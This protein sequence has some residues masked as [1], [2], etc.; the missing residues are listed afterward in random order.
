MANMTGNEIKD[1]WD[2]IITAYKETER[3]D[4]CIQRV[5]EEMNLEEALETFAAIAQIKSH[6]GRIYGKNRDEMEKIS[7]D[8]SCLK[9]E[10][11]NPLVYKGLDEIHPTHINQLITELLKERDAREMDD[12]E[13][14]L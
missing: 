8:E 14:E 1:C 13:P 6:D 12:I 11:G 2:K 9:W 7:V 3:P 4:H 5:L 10:H